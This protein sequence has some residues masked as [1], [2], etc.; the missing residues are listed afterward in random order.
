MEKQEVN[1]TVSGQVVLTMETIAS[2]QV[3]N[4]RGSECLLIQDR[5]ET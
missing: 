3:V 1:I 2:L 5:Q 4:K